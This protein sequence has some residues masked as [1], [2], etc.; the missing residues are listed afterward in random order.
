MP[1]EKLEE[2]EE[3][4][5]KRTSRLPKDNPVLQLPTPEWRSSVEFLG[6]EAELAWIEEELHSGTRPVVIAGLGGIGKTALAV[7][8]RR[9]WEGQVYFARFDTSFTRT[10]AGSVG[11]EIPPQ[12]RRGLNEEQTA[13]L[14]LSYLR[15]RC[16]G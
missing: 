13:E 6:R 1:Q 2:I 10:L 15:C 5:R 9:R 8:F 16:H 4:L 14:A 11:M 3:F 7:K 12:E